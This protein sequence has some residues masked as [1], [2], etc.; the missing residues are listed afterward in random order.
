VVLAAPIPAGDVSV[1]ST[2]RSLYRPEAIGERSGIVQVI[3]AEHPGA[4]TMATRPFLAAQALECDSRCARS[5]AVARGSC[6]CGRSV[7]GGRS[8]W[9]Q[10]AEAVPITDA[11]D[12]IA[13]RM[14]LGGAGE[15]ERSPTGPRAQSWQ[16]G[17][18]QA[19]QMRPLGQGGRLDS[20]GERRARPS[21][22]AVGMVSET[23]SREA[24]SRCGEG[25]TAL[26]LGACRWLKRSFRWA[27][28]CDR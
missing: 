11:I 27:G 24:H 22:R 17:A 16:L 18:W 12:A 15:V 6:T 21:A 19:V 2:P 26:L 10:R 20:A 1:G 7:M 9:S 14:V 13:G 23:K 4:L 25:S 8:A 5:K 28:K 3:G